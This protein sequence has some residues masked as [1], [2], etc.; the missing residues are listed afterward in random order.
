MSNYPPDFDYDV[1]SGVH[2]DCVRCEDAEKCF[3]SGL[4]SMREMLARFVEQG[5]N[6]EIAE[7]IRLN[8]NPSWGDDPGKPDTI[9]EN[10]DDCL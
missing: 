4:R 3:H 8:W 9:A 1:D 2:D 5:G 6:P 7:S 10:W